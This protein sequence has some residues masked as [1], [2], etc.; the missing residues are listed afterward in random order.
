[1][2]YGNPFEMATMKLVEYA[3]NSPG[4]MAM[5][6]AG[7]YGGAYRGPMQQG[8]MSQ[9]QMG[10]QPAMAQNGGR[11]GGGGQPSKPAVQAEQSLQQREKQMFEE[12]MRRGLLSRE[13]MR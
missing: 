3:G 6:L 10:G 11:A 1:M 2:R 8:V 4:L 9:Q 13:M 12:E 5:D 7:Q